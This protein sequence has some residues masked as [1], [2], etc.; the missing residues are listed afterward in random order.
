MTRLGYV[1]VDRL[2]DDDSDQHEALRRAGVRRANIFTD[3]ASSTTT[4]SS[5]P[6][7]RLLLEE[8]RPGDTVVVSRLSTLGGDPTDVALTL[9]A[10]E[11]MGA[12]VRAVHEGL[13]TGERPGPTLEALAV[14]LAPSPPTLK[15]SAA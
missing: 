1:R 13:D 11:L 6:G 9:G 12:S 2:G 3:T 10:L 15:P 14:M 8:L 5:R 4:A 7:W